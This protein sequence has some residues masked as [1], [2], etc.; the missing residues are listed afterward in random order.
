[1]AV[2]CADFV[3]I[4]ADHEPTADEWKNILSENGFTEEQI[5]VIL[6]DE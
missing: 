3:A 1:V 4:Q 5:D 2:P 6:A